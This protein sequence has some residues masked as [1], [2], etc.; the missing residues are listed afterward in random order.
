MAHAG[1]TDYVGVVT[2][3]VG[4]V[5][6]VAGSIMGF[7]GYRRSNQIKSFD[8]RV[9]LQKDLTEA[10]ES[11]NVLQK[12]IGSAEGS[13]RSTLAARGLGRSGA[14]DVWVKA[15]ASDREEA[16]RI[17]ASIPSASADYSSMPESQLEDAIISAHRAKIA[18]SVLIEKYRGE[19]AADDDARRQIGQQATTMAAARLNQA[20]QRGPYG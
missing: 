1:W 11:V 2:G 12:L 7:L 14:M 5:T 20:P 10:R 15:I 16:E 4:T 3:I 18:L 17:A 6:G 8:L 13:R 9:A 19:L